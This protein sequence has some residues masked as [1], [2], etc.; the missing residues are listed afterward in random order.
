LKRGEVTS[1]CTATSKRSGE[2]C[3]FPATK[4]CGG[5]C[6]WHG[7]NGGDNRK[8]V[9]PASRRHLANLEIKRARLWADA[10]VAQRIA[11]NEIHPEARKALKDYIGRIHPADEG[12]ALLA[13]DRW[14]DG[15]M[16]NDGWEEARRALGL[17]P[18]RRWPAP[19]PA[20]AAA[21]EPQ[22]SVVELWPTRSSKS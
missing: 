9:L 4:G 13:L 10:E 11:A 19:T 7:A 14:F 5:V 18:P 1:R 22:A 2:R 17:I 21:S 6:Y 15:A 20:S 8:R 16:T 3:R 12:R